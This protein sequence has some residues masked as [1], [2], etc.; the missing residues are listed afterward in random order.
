MELYNYRPGRLLTRWICMQKP[1]IGL[2]TAWWTIL[3]VLHDAPDIQNANP[4]LA[5]LTILS[6][7]RSMRYL[8][9]MTFEYKIAKSLCQASK[10]NILKIG[11]PLSN[12]CIHRIACRHRYPQN[13]T[14]AGSPKRQRWDLCVCAPPL[15]CLKKQVY[16][17]MPTYTYTSKP[18]RKATFSN[19]EANNNCNSA[20]QSCHLELPLLKVVLHSSSNVN[21]WKIWGPSL[22]PHKEHFAVRPADRFW[23]MQELNFPS[24]SRQGPCKT[25]SFDWQAN[26]PRSWRGTWNEWSV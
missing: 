17:Y 24:I 5:T 13:T 10:E 14:A 15:W 4:F 26:T 23:Q 8:G 22:L 16:E 7:K 20:K 1:W 11:H 18:T 9:P 12:R 21:C 19:K 25:D 3:L 6:A 2:C